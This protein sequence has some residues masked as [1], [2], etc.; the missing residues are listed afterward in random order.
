MKYFSDVKAHY[1][2]HLQLSVDDDII[3]TLFTNIFVDTTAC[4]H[5]NW[6]ENVCYPI[7]EYIRTNWYLSS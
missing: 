5:S 7:K 6:I 2:L 3:D 1:L 4:L